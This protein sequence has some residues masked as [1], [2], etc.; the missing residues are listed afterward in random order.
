MKLFVIICVTFFS[1]FSIAIE[2]KPALLKKGDAKIDL[3]FKGYAACYGMDWRV[4]KAV[5]KIESDIKRLKS[6]DLSKQKM[7]ESDNIDDFDLT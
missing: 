5:A 4:L 7:L 1:T 6:T 2:S 3:Y